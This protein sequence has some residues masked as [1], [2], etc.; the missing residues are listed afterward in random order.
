MGYGPQPS[1]PLQLKRGSLSLFCVT[2][3]SLSTMSETFPLSDVV[4]SDRRRNP[5]HSDSPCTNGVWK[6]FTF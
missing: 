1:F 4:C 5:L 3:E 6:V 2:K